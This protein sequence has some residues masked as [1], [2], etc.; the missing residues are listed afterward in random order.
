LFEQAM[1]TQGGQ[2]DDPTA[3]VKRLNGILVELSQD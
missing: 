3:F 1:L 2:L